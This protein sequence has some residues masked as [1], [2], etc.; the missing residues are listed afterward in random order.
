MAPVLKV[1]P[2]LDYIF[3]LKTLTRTHVYSMALIAD[4]DFVRDIAP[5]LFF[6]LSN[7]F[8]W[9]FSAI[10]RLMASFI[11][12]SEYFF[13]HALLS[14]YF[15]NICSRL[16]NGLVDTICQVHLVK[17]DNILFL[18]KVVWSKVYMRMISQGILAMDRSNLPPLPLTA[19][20]RYQNNPQLRPSD[21][22]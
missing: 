5:T 10:I 2:T 9:Y 7:L 20:W 16:P 4:H 17:S 19:M 1:Y 13:L 22:S 8:H 3:I 18:R 12:C 14:F 15:N 11:Y 21:E 6:H